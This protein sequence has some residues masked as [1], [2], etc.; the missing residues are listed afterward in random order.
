M[1]DMENTTAL[2]V[3]EI[4]SNIPTKQPPNKA[5][6]SRVQNFYKDGKRNTRAISKAL[7]EELYQIWR[8]TGNMCHAARACGVSQV[9]AKKYS[10]LDNWEGRK[11]LDRTSKGNLDSGMSLEAVKQETIVYLRDA[12][13][14]AHAEIS[15]VGYRTAREAATTM[16]E[17]GR[18]E[19]ELMGNMTAKDASLL[20]DAGIKLARLEA[21]RRK[22]E[23]KEVK[24]EVVENKACETEPETPQIEGK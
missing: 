19:L 18:M 22:R 14:L 6:S 11:E 17:C 15:K 10:L 4:D 13:R 1:N 23:G 2:R 24:A 12:R 3:D 8:D 9:T 7:R 16:I 5:M 21:L 20:A